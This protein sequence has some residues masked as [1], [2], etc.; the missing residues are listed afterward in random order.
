M[1]SEL[2]KRYDVAEEATG[3][4][5]LCG[6][7]RLYPAVSKSN[8]EPV[9]VWTFDKKLDTKDLGG[10]KALKEQISQ[11]M[12]RDLKTL[13]TMKHP[14]I[15]QV[16]ETF[17]DEGDNELAIV[18]ERVGCSLANAINLSSSSDGHRGLRRPKTVPFEPYEVSRGV[19]GLA[20]A[21]AYLHSVALKVH[22]NVAPESV[23]LSP[24]GQWKLCGMGFSADFPREGGTTLPCPH[25]MSGAQGRYEGLWRLHPVLKYSSPEATSPVGEAVV[26]PMS[27]TYALGLLAFR[28]YQGDDRTSRAADLIQIREMVPSAHRDACRGLQQDLLARIHELPPGAGELIRGMVAEEPMSRTNPGSVSGN[29]I[30]HQP[31]VAGLRFLDALPQKDP[32]EAATFLSGFRPTV[33]RYPMRI[34]SEVMLRAMLLSAR[35]HSDGRLW[36]LVVPIAADICERLDPG[37]IQGGGLLSVQSMLAPA[38]ARPE[39]ET[40]QSLVDI[41]PL[42]LDKFETK[43]CQ[44]EMISMFAVALT[45]EGFPALQESALKQVSEGEFCNAMSQEIME[46]QVLPRV[47]WLVVKSQQLST[48]VQALLCLAKTFHHFSVAAVVEKVMPTLK[49]AVEKDQSVAVQLCCLGCYDAIARKMEKK[50][51]VAVSILPVVLPILV[52]RD[53]DPQQF[54]LVAG[55]ISAL[56]ELVAEYQRGVVSAEPGGRRSAAADNEAAADVGGMSANSSSDAASSS[57]FAEK[58]AATLGIKS[59]LFSS[60]S[61]NSNSPVAG[62]GSGSGGNAN[63]SNRT[64]YGSMTQASS[65]ATL[66]KP[67]AAAP[68]SVPTT[69][70][71]A[72]PPKPS[73]PP[74]PLPPKGAPAPPSVPVPA[75]PLSF[76]TPAPDP[77]PLPFSTPAPAPAPLPSTLPFST[78]TPS[79]AP[80]PAPAPAPLPSTLPFS[81]PAPAPAPV[82]GT[83]DPNDPFAAL[84]GGSPAPAPVPS[85]GLGVSNLA[86]PVSSSMSAMGAQKSKGPVASASSQPST[87]N[88]NVNV[89]VSGFDFLAPSSLKPVV[90]ASSSPSS[91]YAP[92][93]Q[94]S[95]PQPQ[96]S[97]SANGNNNSGGLDNMFDSFAA[98]SQQLHPT[99]PQQQQQQPVLAQQKPQLSV[100][101]QLQQTQAEIAALQ[102]Q[103]GS[104]NKPQQQR[105]MPQMQQQQQQM[106]PQHMPQMQMP[107]MQMQMQMRPQQQQQQQSYRMMNQQQQRWGQPQQPMM[108]GGQQQQPMGMG[109]GMGM[110]QPQQQYQGGQPQPYP[111]P[112]GNANNASSA[113]AFD[114]LK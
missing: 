99:K 68:P 23:V 77:S 32:S 1:G 108:M 83:H 107:Q 37:E 27:D 111:R 89:N 35:R 36:S 93:P 87:S 53:L 85:I 92:P 16:W 78:L 33:S 82:Q 43:F 94:V 48:R 40:L 97:R 64:S 46:S 54:E 72:V 22:L 7:W 106:R 74:P 59:S 24:T 11:I 5:G 75:E 20:E 17:G 9:T 3:T 12:L 13:K 101:E 76:M 47:C 71:P 105:T 42:C 91:S 73:K 103:L 84:D 6:L 70:T 19:Y 15:V 50:H 88:G 10:D 61:S 80:A 110:M 102:A 86:L 79:P 58:F 104:N 2:S 96:L 60:S 21:L 63:S 25:F 51:H 28:M 62:S 14:S 38:Y 67:P 81:A 8:K 44:S 30:F 56:V 65:S 95:Q 52:H 26:S 29:V 114:F 18:T 113:S 66:S 39:P 100:A 4:A 69:L 109:M 112:Q 34:Q 49:F 45:K 98:S 55:K 41:T 90:P 57:S 31:D